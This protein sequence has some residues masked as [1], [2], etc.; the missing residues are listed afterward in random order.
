MHHVTLAP[1]HPPR[2]LLG[3]LEDLHA[4]AIG[5][6]YTDKL[7]TGWW[8]H[9]SAWRHHR[10]AVL[11]CAGSQLPVIGHDGVQLVFAGQADCRSEMDGI[12]RRDRG[13]RESLG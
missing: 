1:C 8:G 12:E 11:L 9:Q 10:D 2:K 4:V 13:R 7:S 6:Q 3:H 5:V